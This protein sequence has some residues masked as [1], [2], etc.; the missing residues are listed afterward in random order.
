MKTENLFTIFDLSL[1]LSPYSNQTPNS[2]KLSSCPLLPPN[3][4]WHQLFP[5]IFQQILKYHAFY[6]SF[7][8]SVPPFHSLKHWQNDLLK[9]EYNNLAVSKFVEFRQEYKW[10]YMALPLFYLHASAIT[11]RALTHKCY[12]CAFICRQSY[13]YIWLLSFSA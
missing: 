6:Q 10:R 11:A 9:Q 1:H 12:F 8:L 4:R 13:L 7:H 2:I 3:T 5:R